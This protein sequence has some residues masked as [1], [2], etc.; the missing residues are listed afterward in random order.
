MLILN[1]ILWFVF[2]LI[3]IFG[4]QVFVLPFVVNSIVGFYKR[5]RDLDLKL[6]LEEIK[7]KTVYNDKHV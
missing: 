4:F 1:G 3:F 7:D 2:L 5:R 6:K